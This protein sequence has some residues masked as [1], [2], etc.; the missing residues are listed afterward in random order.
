MF[1]MGWPEIFVIG[2]VAVLLFGPDRLPDVARQ[3]GQMI[4][5]VRKMAEAAKND[6]GREL[7]HDLSDVDLRSLDP[8]EVV[9][10]AMSGEPTDQEGSPDPSDANRLKSAD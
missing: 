10:R 6:L 3:A 4:R 2:A 1:G 5:T 7:G 8:R 9:R